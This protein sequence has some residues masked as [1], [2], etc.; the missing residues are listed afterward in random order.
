M[1]EET[2]K[3][4]GTALSTTLLIEGVKSAAEMSAAKQ[5]PSG[6]GG[7]GGMLAGRIMRGRG[8]TQARS[9]V[10]TSTIET[11][12]VAPTVADADVALPAGFRQRN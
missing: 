2:I 11:L 1:S 7:L 8:Q 3:L 5:A 12:S 6:G 9:T 10:M 4:E